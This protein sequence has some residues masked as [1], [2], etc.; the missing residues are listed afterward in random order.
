MTN[1][2]AS[3]QERADL[4]LRYALITLPPILILLLSEIMLFTLADDSVLFSENVL[5]DANF[6]EPGEA[7]SRLKMIG[8]ALLVLI[9][10]FAINLKFASDIKTHF[11][12]SAKNTLF[13][14]YGIVLVAGVLLLAVM[15]IKTRTLRGIAQ[16]RMGDDLFDLVFER[17]KN[18]PDESILVEN[19]WGENVYQILIF[20]SQIAIIFAVAALLAGAI[21]CLAKL[22]RL[23]EKKNWTYQSE[24]LRTYIFIAAGF[25]IFCVLYFQSWADYPAFLLAKES[26]YRSLSNAYTSFIGIEWSLVLAAYALPIFII[27]ARNAD[28]IAMTIMGKTDIAKAINGKAD[29]L[30]TVRSN[31]ALK[32]QVSSIKRK[33]GMELSLAEI[34]RV[35]FAV[36]GPLITGAVANLASAIS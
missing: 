25:L 17:L 18:T 16:E 14:A 32:A 5:K 1:S 35:V 19:V 11:A 31:P 20:I 10:A 33:E 12:G 9:S 7:A 30:G 8:M 2:P 24:R 34:M 23:S 6:S 27:Q 28:E 15:A 26:P 22:P 29:D 36:L 13:R 21:S 3:M 4:S